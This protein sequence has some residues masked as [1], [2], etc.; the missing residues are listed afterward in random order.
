[1]FPSMLARFETCAFAIGFCAAAVLADAGRPVRG[2]EGPKEPDKPKATKVKAEFH[3][4][5]F[6]PIDFEGD[7]A[8]GQGTV[9]FKQP[10]PPGTSAPPD[11]PLN[12]GATV[13]HSKGKPGHTWSS[14]LWVWDSPPVPAKTGGR[15][16]ITPRPAKPGQ[17]PPKTPEPG[18]PGL[19]FGYW[20]MA[21]AFGKEPGA[22][23]SSQRIL[24]DTL[25]EDDGPVKPQGTVPRDDRT[26]TPPAHV[27]G[28]SQTPGR[29]GEQP[30]PETDPG[31][32]SF[33]APGFLIP[34][35]TKGSKKPVTKVVIE[36]KFKTRFFCV[37]KGK[38]IEPAFVGVQWGFKMTVTI[39][40]PNAPA[41]TWTYEVIADPVTPDP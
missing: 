36:R 13:Q 28:T 41:N 24:L 2:Q 33:D 16:V 32:A 6:G 40:S 7:L 15:S 29:E 25:Q 10:P 37:E 39:P 14:Y 3:T 31:E 19:H 18:L 23:E 5:E 1:M 4:K 9:K 20:K 8:S 34:D 21:T 26:E 38:R 11:I 22:M 35:P 17:P 12:L 30:K 27:E